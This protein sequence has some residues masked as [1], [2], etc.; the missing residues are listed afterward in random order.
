MCFCGARRLIFH[1]FRGR[2]V[3]E[4]YLAVVVDSVSESPQN[5]SQSTDDYISTS[6]FKK[7][8]SLFAEL[9]HSGHSGGCFPAG[10]WITYAHGDQAAHSNGR[11]NSLCFGW[12]SSLILVYFLAHV[13]PEAISIY[14]AKILHCDRSN[15]CTSIGREES[16]IKRTKCYVSTL[17]NHASHQKYILWILDRPGQMYVQGLLCPNDLVTLIQPLFVG[18]RKTHIEG[19]D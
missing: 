9:S 19:V 15:I 3:C 4:I 5:S 12:I 13:R 2:G 8:I 16:S 18:L 7:F 11:G 17:I 1:D 14:F 10:D 6:S